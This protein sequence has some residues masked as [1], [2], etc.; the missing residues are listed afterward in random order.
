MDTSRPKYAP[1]ESS[2]EESEDELFPFE[3]K[4]QLLLQSNE[5]VQDITE[6]EKLD[7]RLR[8]LQQREYEEEEE[9]YVEHLNYISIIIEHSNTFFI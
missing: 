7:R 2:E 8:R 9:K 5:A 4:Q 1:E 6:A 3:K